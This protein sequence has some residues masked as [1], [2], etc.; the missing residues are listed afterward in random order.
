[1]SKIQESRASKRA[2]IETAARTLVDE[3]EHRFGLEHV[4]GITVGRN[5]IIVH[6]CDGSD[7][8]LGRWR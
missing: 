1:M 6:F 2:D 7:A 8:A 4:D 5:T 3:V